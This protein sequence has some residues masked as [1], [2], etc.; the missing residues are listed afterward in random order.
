MDNNSVISVEHLKKIY[1]SN[2]KRKSKSVEAVSGID[3]SVNE[4]EI[5]GLLG[6]NGAGKTTT[7][8]ILCT[9]I[10]PTSGNVSILNYN[11]LEYQNEIRNNIG[12]VSQKGGLELRSTGKENL[13]LQARLYGMSIRDSEKHADELIDILDLKSF[14]YRKAKTYSGGQKRLFDLATGIIHKPKILFLDEP[15]TGLD[16]QS[17]SHVWKEVKKLNSNGTTIILTTHY[18][19]EADAL[20]N[21][22][23]IINLG[24]IVALDNPAQLK[25]DIIAG[26]IITLTF[27]NINV[28]QSA[29]EILSG[30]L[31][32]KEIQTIDT[33]LHLYVDEGDRTLPVV[34]SL[35]H[36]NNLY[37]QTASLSRPTLDDVFLKLTGRKLIESETT[38]KKDTQ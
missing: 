32:I 9:L 5:F 4:N 2:G 31:F 36:K 15:T 10:S 6:P 28:Q 29:I 18:L 14:A 12:Y 38:E 8:R 33:M 13:I 24:K 20:C 23:A 30:Q 17:R 1:S 11:L 7:M 21:R 35:L 16:P 25:R 26:D 37:I 19:E 3:F 22:V 27:E 34:M